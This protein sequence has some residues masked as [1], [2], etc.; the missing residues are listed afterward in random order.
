MG[1]LRLNTEQTI[2]AYT[3]GSEVYLKEWHGRT[4]RIPL[5]LQIWIKH[6][7]PRSPV[8]DM[9]CGPGQDSRYL[10]RRGFQVVGLDRTGP[11]LQVARRRSPRLP[12]VQADIEHLPFSPNT[13]AGI[14]AAASLIHL[15]QSALKKVLRQIRIRTRPGGVFAATCLHGKGEGF[16]PDQWI[17]GRY[18]RQWLKPE[19]EDI[20]QQTGWDI[21]S[22]QTVTNRERKGRWLNLIAKLGT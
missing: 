21:I 10:R 3:S 18:V 5:H 13:F 7:P 1:T 2:Q 4:Y 8:L 9:G 16:L 14:W 11:F 6:L 22:L 12:L 19:L 15:P 17:P 20:I